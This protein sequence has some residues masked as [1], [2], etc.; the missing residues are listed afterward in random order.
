MRLQAV[1]TGREIVIQ[2]NAGKFRK[3]R[4]VLHILPY[5]T[6]EAAQTEEDESVYSDPTGL[7]KI[8]Q[9]D[10]WWKQYG[11]ATGKPFTGLPK[12]LSRDDLVDITAQPLLNFL[13]ALSYVRGKLNFSTQINLNEIYE[14][15]LEAVHGRAYAT[16]GTLPGIHHIE[17][18]DF[19]RIL[20]EIGLAAWRGDGRTT[21]ISAIKEQCE[22]GGLSRLL[23]EFK[24]GAEAGVAQ[25][26]TAFY[27]RQHGERREGEARF[28]FTHKSFGEYLTARRLMRALER[29]HSEYERHL[30]LPD[31]GWVE[32]ECLRHWAALFVD[33]PRMTADLYRFVASEMILK[34][35]PF[36]ARLQRTLCVLISYFLQHGTPMERMTPRLSFWVELNTAISSEEALLAA[37]YACALVTQRVSKIGWSVSAEEESTVAGEWIGRLRGQRTDPRNPLALECLGLLSLQ[38]CVL[39]MRDLYG[40]NLGGSD[41]ADASLFYANLTN[42]NLIGSKLRRANLWQANL[43]RARLETADLR[44]ATLNDADLEGAN[45][46]DANLGRARLQGTNLKNAN[47]Q[48]SNL[49]GADM[50]GD[51]ERRIIGAYLE[52]ANLEEA[53]LKKADLRGANLV[54]ANL[55]GANFTNADL[56]NADLT[57]AMT[58]GAIFDGAK[59]EGAKG[60]EGLK[61]ADE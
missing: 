55:K 60:L 8:D 45:L 23:A 50:A 31:A 14:D 32:A 51:P 2:A 29:I 3:D 27:F 56:R 59:L 5:Y 33:S 1:I 41:L 19:I 18:P 10:L 40:A 48:R 20:E 47:L 52:N 21:T 12:E 35:K 7:L 15:L 16:G 6:A 28:E 30:Q 39:H 24:E 34:R 46:Q 9:R 61:S 25:L 13:V 36:V 57:G 49:Q 58:D 11:V 4:Q 26:L 54:G 37:L 17:L 53:N 44:E 42:A 38:G 43:A 22:S